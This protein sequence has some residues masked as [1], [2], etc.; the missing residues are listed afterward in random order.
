MREVTPTRSAAL[1]LGDE[2]KLMR[3]GYEFL[4]EKRILLATEI[5]QQV[6]AYRQEFDVLTVRLKEAAAALANAVE[7]HGIDHLQTYPTPAVAPARAGGDRR[8]FLGIP[9][10]TSGQV[11][12]ST[13][14]APAALDPSPE[15]KACRA[16]FERLAQLAA[17]MGARAGNLYRLEREYRRTDRRAKALENVLLPEVEDAIKRV[18]EQLDTMEREEAIR[19]RWSTN[20]EAAW[21]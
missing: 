10:L 18:D 19:A 1:E 17:E 20:T 6:R 9:L 21:R 5:L 16:A 14:S 15:A 7:R 8:L 12:A 3:Q 2:R 4:D 13:D 11:V